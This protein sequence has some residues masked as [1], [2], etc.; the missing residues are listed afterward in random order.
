MVQPW[1]WDE[2]AGVYVTIRSSS[3]HMTGCGACRCEVGY[4]PPEALPHQ[5]LTT[6]ADIYQLGGLCYF[7]ATGS[8]PPVS[9]DPMQLSHCM[10]ED[11]CLL[12]CWCRAA[13]PSDRPT[14]AHLRLHLFTLCQHIKQAPQST[15]SSAKLTPAQPVGT[16]SSGSGH[17]LPPMAVTQEAPAPIEAAAAESASVLPRMAANPLYCPVSSPSQLCRSDVKLAPAAPA[18]T[19]PLAAAAKAA[20]SGVRSH[21]S[22]AS[23]ALGVGAPSSLPQLMPGVEQ[24]LPEDSITCDSPRQ[25]STPCSHVAA[26]RRQPRVAVP[27]ATTAA[28]GS[29]RAAVHWNRLAAGSSAAAH[30]RGD[31]EAASASVGYGFGDKGNDSQAGCAEQQ[32][33]YG[34]SSEAGE[35]LRA[36]ASSLEPPAGPERSSGELAGFDNTSPSTAASGKQVG[37]VTL[38]TPSAGL[39][40]AKIGKS[41]SR[42]RFISPL[43]MSQE[44]AEHSSRQQEA[45]SAGKLVS[46][47]RF[48]SSSGLMRS[49]DLWLA[50]RDDAAL[51]TPRVTGSMAQA[52]GKAAG[53]AASVELRAAGLADQQSALLQ[54][55]ISGRGSSRL[56]SIVGHML[57]ISEVCL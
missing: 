43:T 5:P 19:L 17:T 36:V 37:V 41:Y 13:N 47:S 26:A 40:S 20:W 53:L 24:W 31:A 38:S 7:M 34:Q 55:P 49:P 57:G 42:A 14:A 25:G 4:V 8:H 48:P 54:P 12:V 45:A 3:C 6:A 22:W 1:A 28:A 46:P 9:L 11:W 39:D 44:G 18:Q 15:G 51:E 27:D 50:P 23:A 16:S 30:S 33:L 21:M 29:A 2:A 32:C 52:Q 56:G 35:V 10:P